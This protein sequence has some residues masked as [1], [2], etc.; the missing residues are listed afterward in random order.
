MTKFRYMICLLYSGRCFGVET[1][2]EVEKE[3]SY[4]ASTGKSIGDIVV[5]DTLDRKVLSITIKTTVKAV[6]L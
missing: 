2:P 4:L 6:V 3:I 5:V 1:I